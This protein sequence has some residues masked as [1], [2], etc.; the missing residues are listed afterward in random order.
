[1]WHKQNVPELPDDSLN[2]EISRICLFKN[3]LRAFHEIK[4][5][6][7]LFLKVHQQSMKFVDELS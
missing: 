4:W 2:H 5:S 1:M 6:M 7:S 3:F